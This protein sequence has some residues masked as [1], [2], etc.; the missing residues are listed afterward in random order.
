MAQTFH[1]LSKITQ[2]PP[3]LPP[4][5]HQS[6][7]ILN[8]PLLARKYARAYLST[9]SPAPAPSTSAF[10]SSSALTLSALG[11]STRTPL[12]NNIAISNNSP[13]AVALRTQIAK[14]AREALEEQ[15]WDALQRT[16]EARAQE[17]QVGGD[18]SAGN[19]VRAFVLLRH[20]RNGEWED[21]IEVNDFWRARR[22]TW[23]DIE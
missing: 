6:A 15:Y 22:S 23:T 18:P 13:E 9:S 2:E 20:W 4:L 19:L 12:R 5:E 10:S 21:R 7:H 1:V 14:G 3:S 17:A 8:T 11:S 16:L